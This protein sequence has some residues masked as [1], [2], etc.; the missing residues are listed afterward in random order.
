MRF[1]LLLVLI[2]QALFASDYDCIVVGTSPF[3]LFEALYQSHSGKKVLILE[4]A[5]E[6]GGAWKAI[7]VC[8]IP[9]VD[10]GC[11][12][13]GHDMNLKVFLETYAGCHIVSM[14]NPTSRYEASNSPNGFYFSHGCFELID[15]LTQLVKAANIDLLLNHKVES[16]AIE[17]PQKSAVVKTKNGWFRTRK[18]IVTPMSAFNIENST[19][20]QPASKSKYYHLYLLIHDPSPPRFTYHG[21]SGVAGISRIMN[22]TQFA[23]LM[24][25]GQQ[26]L[27]FQTHN[28]QSLTNG[29]AFLDSLKNKNLVDRSA[30]I[31]K[32]ESRIY[33]ASYLNQSMIQQMNAGEFFEVLNTGH[34]QSLSTY[35]AK[36]KQ[37]LKP[38]ENAI[39]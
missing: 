14:D 5:S 11:H 33:E 4:E 2:S 18:L 3:S 21:S 31:L 28:E 36:W 7:N 22:L 27:V 1:I 17:F 34:F 24:N 8:G 35:I 30:Y 12:Q 32:E 16:V 13:I 38:F 23:G 6:C 39:Q 9:H 29:Q 37:V 15:H 20:Q 25:T 19:V 10:L 26:I